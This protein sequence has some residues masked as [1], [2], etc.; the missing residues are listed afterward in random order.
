MLKLVNYTCF[1]VLILKSAQLNSIHMLS[2]AYIGLMPT[3]K[4][5]N[6]KKVLSLAFS[7]MLVFYMYISFL[8]YRVS[9]VTENYLKNCKKNVIFRS[10]DLKGKNSSS[11][12]PEAVHTELWQN[13]PLIC[14]AFHPPFNMSAVTENRNKG[15]VYLKDIL[16][17]NFFANCN[18]SLVEL[19]LHGPLLNCVRNRYSLTKM[20]TTVAIFVQDPGLL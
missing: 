8:L 7:I 13:G 6:I 17:G 15:L 9:C 12:A 5:N 10:P 4:M 16:V 20:A 3:F 14:P 11:E 19:S 1:I 18:Q 2:V